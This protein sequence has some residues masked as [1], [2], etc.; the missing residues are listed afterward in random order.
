MQSL[1]PGRNFMSRKFLIP[2]LTAAFLA[3]P[4]FVPATATS[5][6]SSAA[7]EST[8]AKS[9][10]SNSS[11]RAINLNSSRSNVKTKQPNQT[12]PAGIAINDEGRPADK[13][14]TKPKNK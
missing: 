1:L 10:K 13:P 11:D 7:A 4:A 3:T 14:P 12:G 9:T 6:S 5:L 2:L 8:T